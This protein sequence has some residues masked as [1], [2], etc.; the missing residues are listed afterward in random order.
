MSSTQFR[1][2]GDVSDNCTGLQPITEDED[3]DG[4]EVCVINCITKLLVLV[5]RFWTHFQIGW[6]LFI[7]LGLRSRQRMTIPKSSVKRST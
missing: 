1:R 7:I 3:G 4:V 6:L 2:V 5:V